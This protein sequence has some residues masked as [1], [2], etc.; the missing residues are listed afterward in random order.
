VKG[1]IGATVVGTSVKPSLGAGKG[2]NNGT[3]VVVKLHV[4]SAAR[5][6][7]AKSF[8][9]GS[10]LPPL[11]LTVYVTR[12]ARSTF[13]F[14]A[15]EKD[16]PKNTVAGTKAF[17]GS[18]SSIV[19]VFTV[20]G[21]IDSLKFTTT[22]VSTVAVAPAAGENEATVGGLVSANGFDGILGLLLDILQPE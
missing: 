20:E 22:F 1:K 4:T 16:P 9:R 6:L 8:T 5:A 2:T 17:D 14:S 19:E 3:G 12:G 11:T 21:S 10:V 15:A 18:R 13:G 7:P